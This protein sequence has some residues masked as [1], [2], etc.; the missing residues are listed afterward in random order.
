M[1]AKMTSIPQFDLF[2]EEVAPPCVPADEGVAR[3]KV[4]KSGQG[5]LSAAQ[6]RF[7]KLLARVDNLARQ[8]QD[9][10]RLASQVRAPHLERMTA[11]DRLMGQTQA[12]MVR[13]LHDRLQRK[14]LTAAQKKSAHAIVQTLL[15]VVNQGED[16]PQWAALR[17]VY[18]GPET[19][20]K[21]AQAVREGKQQ[22]IDALEDAL[23]HSFDQEAFDEI[24]SPHALL[25]EAMRQLEARVAAEQERRSAR[26]PT[27]KQ[28]KV[29]EQTQDAKAAMR[30]IYRQLAS[31]LH[32]DRETDPVERERKSALMGQANAAYERGDLTTL[33]RLQLQAEQVDAASISRMADDRL[34][35]LSLLLKQQVAVLEGEV[36]DAEMRLSG[37]L[38]VTVS[39]TMQLPLLSR[40]LQQMQ[41]EVADVANTMQ[42]DLERVRDDAQLKLWLREQAAITRQVERD[43]AM[44][45]QFGGF[46]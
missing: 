8:I 6:L 13:F 25:E 39:A 36:F 11:L 40:L 26:K 5:K 33:L 19:Q 37:E 42:Q 2:G 10:E 14:G 1:V 27:A 22:V 35:A 28:R 45:M 12:D 3:L 15:E 24:D 46:Y 34:A 20:E 17:A 30:S 32:P 41:Q 44:R 9:V 31:A 21:T 4:Q 16:D 18:H 29:R 7:N 38:G 43:Q 23:G